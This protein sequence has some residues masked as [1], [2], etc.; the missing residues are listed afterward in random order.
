M[1]TTLAGLLSSSSIRVN[2]DPPSP[3]TPIADSISTIHA[4][5]SK[6]DPHTSLSSGFLSAASHLHSYLLHLSTSSA[7]SAHRELVRTNSLLQSAMRR[8]DQELKHHLLAISDAQST[9]DQISTIRAIVETMLSTGY[10]EEC[11]TTYQSIRRSAVTSQLKQLGFDIS[12]NLSRKL[13]KVSW[14]A[15]DHQTKLWIDASSRAVCRVFYS[16]RQL[17]DSI[18]G[19]SPEPIR[20]SVFASVVGDIAS[21]FFSFPET[22]SVRARNSPERLF[23]I[24]DMHEKITNLIPDIEVLFGCEPTAMVLSKVTSAIT[25]LIDAARM[26]LNEFE[27]AVRKAKPHSSPGGGILSLSWYVM[28]YLVCLFDYEASLHMILGSMPQEMNTSSFDIQISDDWYGSPVS[29]RIAWLIHVLLQKLESMAESYREVSLSYLFLVNN[30]QYVVKKVKNS[31]LKDSLGEEWVV[32][33]EKKVRR[34]MEGHVRSAWA[35]VSAALPVK[36]E[37][38]VERVREF[39]VVFQKAMKE[40]ESWVIVDERMREEVRQL[41]EG[42]VVPAYRSWYQVYRRTLEVRFTPEFIRSRI[43]G[44]YE[45]PDSRSDFNSSSSSVSGSGSN[46]SNSPKLLCRLGCYMPQEGDLSVRHQEE[47]E[48]ARK[49][50]LLLQYHSR[51]DV[52]LAQQGEVS[53]RLQIEDVDSSIS[54]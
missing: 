14:E 2:P 8:L 34:Y 1:P 42:M 41:V 7:N 33:Q 20:D 50:E 46:S 5:L 51:D 26:S 48:E 17:S 38:H 10:G 45:D 39:E 27:K 31:S 4:F 36:E 43:L 15:M 52:A 49:G 21:T 9:A 25:N 24:L 35:N 23:S 22:V 54:E 29:V 12:L 13:F 44:L 32:A 30:L 6:W 47:L 19:A 18:F 16:E 53:L 40:R 28:N 11:I 3:S 37:E